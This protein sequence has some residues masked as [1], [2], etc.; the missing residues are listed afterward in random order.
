MENITVGSSTFTP[1][2]VSPSA[3][4]SSIW[5]S[6][7]AGVPPMFCPSITHTTT[8]NASKTNI[9]ETILVEVPVPVT[10]DGVVK[11][12]NRYVARLT[13]SALQNV[14]E[15]AKAA[16]TIDAMIGFLTARREE[17]LAASAL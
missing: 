12:P 4:G 17:I 2:Q 1:Y 8:L 15:D 10:V 13:Y 11:A 7:D 9:N 6:S 3:L 14:N 16:L 5:K